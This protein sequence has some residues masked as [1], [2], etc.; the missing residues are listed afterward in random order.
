MELNL[1]EIWQSMGLPV[2]GVVIVL[3]I[4]AIACFAVVMDRIVLLALSSK[5]ARKFA[6]AVEPLMQK[7]DYDEVLEHSRK[8][9]S[10]HLSGY[11]EVGLSMFTKRRSAGDEIER[12]AELARRALERK[13]DMLSRDLS[14]GMNTLAST[15]STAPFVGLLGTVL[16]IIHAFK[17]IASSGSGGI[18]TIG[19]A[20]GESLVVTGYGLCIA[21]PAVLVFNWLSS[22]ISDYESGLINAG[23]EL[24]DRLEMQDGHAVDAVSSSAPGEA[25]AG[26]RAVVVAN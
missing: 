22:K 18:G 7:A 24:I 11:L 20:I 10:N 8:A 17:L 4:Q 14:K 16:G 6:E 3:T 1:V 13:G 9:Q 25:H 2:R 15:G 23:S 19:A 21:I 5:R 26:A 12:A